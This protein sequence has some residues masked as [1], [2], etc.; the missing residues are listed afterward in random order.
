M[1]GLFLCCSVLGKS[2]ILISEGNRPL[3]QLI[4]AAALYTAVVISLFIFVRNF[5][6][7]ADAKRLRTAFDPLKIALLLLPTALAFSIV[8]DV[9]FDLD[10]KKYKEQYCLGRIKFGRWHDLPK[11]E[12][13]SVFRQLKRN[14]DIVFEVNLWYERNKHFTIYEHKE[15]EP[16]FSMGTSVSNSLNVRL[17]DATVPNN[18]KWLG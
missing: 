15:L 7:T 16:V 5:E 12:Y 17:L 18:H 11:I 4:L 13:V 6:F 8:K 1:L 9:L 3:W 14:G 10:E 2:K